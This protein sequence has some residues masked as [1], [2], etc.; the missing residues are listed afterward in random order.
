VANLLEVS[1]LRK[2]AVAWLEYLRNYPN[3][4]PDLCGASLQ[5]CDLSEVYLRDFDLTGANFTG[6]NLT[7]ADLRKTNFSHANFSGAILQNAALTGTRLIETCFEK[8][9][10]SNAHLSGVDSSRA[11]FKNARLLKSN[12]SESWFWCS[13][14]EGAN[15]EN[16]WLARSNLEKAVL[17][18]ANLAG[19]DLTASILVD[20]KLNGANLSG[21]RVFGISNWK[22]DLEGAIQSN[23]IITPET[24]PDISVDNLK[25]AQFIYLLLNNSDIREAIDSITA[26]V[27]LIIGRFTAERKSILDAIRDALRKYNYI[28]V[29]FDFGR[30]ASK[31]I[32][33]TINILAGMSRFVVAD[34]TE[35]KIVLQELHNI[36]RDFPSVPVQ[37]LLQRGTQPTEILLDFMDYSSFLDIYQYNDCDDLLASISRAIIEPAEAKAHEIRERRKKAEALLSDLRT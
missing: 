29:M 28:P 7:N 1:I 25:V 34:I 6:A 19:A 31:N 33:E 11:V 12:M 37:P 30:P 23:L 22:C 27:V 35:P 26:K 2:G 32:A 15:L 13:N 10:L 3:C 18:N 20:A 14:F 21:C 17:T 16:A 24:E 8:A 5:G 9:D 36:L 4:R